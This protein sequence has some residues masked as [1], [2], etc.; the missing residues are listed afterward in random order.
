[1]APAFVQSKS[2]SSGSSPSTTI[3]AS[4]DSNVTES[5]LIYVGTKFY[6]PSE[7]DDTEAQG[8]T[9]SDSQSN[10]YTQ[11]NTAFEDNI[12]V[13]SCDF[14]AQG[15]TGG[16][17]TVTVT[18]P[19]AWGFRHLLIAEYSG[20]HTSSAL[21]QSSVTADTTFTTGTDN[22]ATSNITTTNDDALVIGFLAD[23]QGSTTITAGTNYT[24]R[25]DT[26][27][28]QIEDRILST[29]GSVN[30]TWTVTNAHHGSLYVASFNTQAT[31]IEKTLTVA[32]ETDSS[33]ALSGEERVSITS[34]SESDLARLLETERR[35]TSVS[36]TDT[37]Q[38]L[39]AQKQ[40]A[41]T[42]A[43]ET[44]SSQS[45]G[46]GTPLE[47][48]AQAGWVVVH[49]GDRYRA[50]RND[51]G[52]KVPELTANS[53]EEL[54]EKVNKR[55]ERAFLRHIARLFDNRVILRGR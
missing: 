14:Y 20:V 6:T 45:F 52:L 55:N 26:L 44:D 16:A 25:E 22:T 32:T 17:N 11:I 12:E 47:Q 41:I 18:Y 29:A 31:P 7:S 36:E 4:F 37:A 10:T 8:T 19:N 43:T 35:V 9:C 24:E 5:N 30:A 13:N 50:V 54:L 39:S 53:L 40:I 38:A 34:A 49:Q 23:A 15:I 2:N 46:G 42:Q 1:M 21:D 51:L 33:Q 3:A 28:A 27:E 48:I